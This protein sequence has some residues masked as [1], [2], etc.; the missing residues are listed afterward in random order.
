MAEARQEQGE[1]SDPP[2]AMLPPLAETRGKASGDAADNA[3]IPVGPPQLPMGTSGGEAED[4][5]SAASAGK[6]GNNKKAWE[7]TAIKVGRPRKQAATLDPATG[8]LMVRKR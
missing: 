2:P 8:A 6:G 4:E 3:A 7:F 1:A 5:A